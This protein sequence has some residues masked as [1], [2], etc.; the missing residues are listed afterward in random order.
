[1]R[2]LDIN[3][4][5]FDLYRAL[6]PGFD[7]SFILESAVGESRTVAHSFLGFGP[8]LVLKCKGGKV[9]GGEGL[10]HLRE[11]PMAFL[12]AFM[13]ERSIEDQT[14]SYLGGLVGYF[15]Y[16]FSGL[17]EPS[18]IGKEDRDFPV[19]ELGFY[20]E[21]I[22]YDHSSFR[23]Y[24]FGDADSALLE[25]LGSHRSAKEPRISFG[26][27][28]EVSSRN[29]F[30]GAV[31]EAKRRIFDGEI[32]QVVL[33]R[34]NERSYDGN[35]LALYAALR[36]TNPSPYMFYL[37]HGPRTVLGSS[38]ETLVSLRKGELTTFPIAG[39]RPI[40]AAPKETRR[41][42]EEMLRDEKERAEHCMLVDLA[43]ND[44][45]K[46]CE[47]ETVHVP[48]FMQVESFSHVQHIVSKVQGTLAKGKGAVDALAALFPAG[49]VSGAPKPRA[50]EIIA[51][52][53][54]RARGPYAGGVGYLSLNGNLDSAI[55]IRSAFCAEGV[56]RTQAGAG[57]V[58][59]SDP[60]REYLETE[61]KLG[62]LNAS[63]SMLE[64]RT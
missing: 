36:A 46:V 47:V 34:G 37:D 13:D 63:F 38:P 55:A 42:R 22:V 17:T 60:S 64:A 9:E 7:A 32:F 40:G 30:E 33:S 39:T 15:S 2:R 43:R 28:R 16:E 59:D 11:K 8:E 35:P 31:I 14:F 23:A 57:I 56:L 61:Q 29:E 5:P 58:A 1:M 6:A 44:I 21:G 41:F 53:E 51:E 3:V 25:A 48:E 50:M 18:F 10:D 19:F 27:E 20:S 45:G 49:T 62:A 54:G 52:L 24:H 4:P 12:K 26:A